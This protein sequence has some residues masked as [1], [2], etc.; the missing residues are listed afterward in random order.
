MHNPILEAMTL[1]STLCGTHQAHYKLKTEKFQNEQSVRELECEFWKSFRE[2]TPFGGLV[3]DL[4]TAFAS[5]V[6]QVTAKMPG[7]EVCTS[8]RLHPEMS[9]TKFTHSCISGELFEYYIFLHI[10][11]ITISVSSWSHNTPKYVSSADFNAE[12]SKSRG[13]FLLQKPLSETFGEH[14][15]QQFQTIQVSSCTI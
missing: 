10:F 12:M 15:D 9:K 11:Q 2:T 14:Y 1:L 3:N 8:V 4:E 6:K 13:Q 7:V 5:Y